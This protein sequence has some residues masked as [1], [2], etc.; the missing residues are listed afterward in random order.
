LDARN[1]AVPP[2]IVAAGVRQ[3]YLSSGDSLVVQ[4]VRCFLMGGVCQ[5]WHWQTTLSDKRPVRVLCEG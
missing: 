3:G 4:L 5:T 1:L 2:A